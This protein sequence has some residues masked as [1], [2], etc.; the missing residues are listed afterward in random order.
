MPTN[1]IT[2]KFDTGRLVIVP[3]AALLLGINILGMQKDMG[4]LGTIN[5]TATATLVHRLLI[6]CFYALWIVLYLVRSSAKATTTSYFAKT[7]AVIAAFMPF[8]IPSV[9]QPIRS[10]GIMLCTNSISIL[11]MAITLYSLSVL[12]KNLSIIPQAR[13]LVQGG[14]YRLVRHPVYLGELITLFGI[15]IA[16]FSLAGMTLFCLFSASQIYRAAQE[17]RLLAGTFPE[18]KSY[19]LKRARFIPGI[20]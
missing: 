1:H 12:G 10:L 6:I 4:S 11:G 19:S 16:R 13:S 14:P 20:Y 18:Y 7:I 5:A 8:V 2:H 17:E 15:V 9:S 3:V